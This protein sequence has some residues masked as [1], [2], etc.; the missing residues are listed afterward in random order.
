MYIYIMYILLNAIAVDN[1]VKI[2]S[3]VACCPCS[4]APVEKPGTARRGAWGRSP[5]GL[6]SPAEG[7]LPPPWGPGPPAEGPGAPA[8]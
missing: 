8:P 5:R 6:G 7:P 2:M 4:Q 3:C 1:V